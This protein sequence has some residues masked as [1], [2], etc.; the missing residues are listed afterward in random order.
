MRVSTPWPATD[1][2]DRVTSALIGDA[3]NSDVLV[4]G[5]YMLIGSSDDGQLRL[6]VRMQDGK[7]GEILSEVGEAGETEEIFR[8]VSQIGTQLRIFVTKSK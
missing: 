8:L 2:L 1:T 4:L 5:S 3:L 6:D 7:T